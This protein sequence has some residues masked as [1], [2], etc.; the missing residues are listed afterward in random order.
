MHFQQYE[1][2]VPFL[3]SALEVLSLCRIQKST[4][5]DSENL[6]KSYMIAVRENIQMHF[7]D[8]FSKHSLKSYSLKGYP[9]KTFAENVYA[10]KIFLNYKPKIS[11]ISWKSFSM[12]FDLNIMFYPTLECKEL[13]AAGND[14]VC[15]LSPLSKVNALLTRTQDTFGRKQIE[16]SQCQNRVSKT[17]E[18][19]D[20]RLTNMHISM[21]Q[22]RKNVKQLKDNI[23]L[24]KRQIANPTIGLCNA[25]VKEVSLVRSLGLQLQPKMRLVNN[26]KKN[27]ERC[28][29]LLTEMKT[30]KRRLQH[31]HHLYVYNTCN[32]LFKI[33]E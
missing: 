13:I 9:Q 2:V 30:M 3:C 11:K 5:E 18:D 20:F 27:V 22:L 21:Q 26:K 28:L 16:A 10:L 8:L 12:L 25:V 19:Y 1:L 32:T 29:M 17:L 24:P 14:Y 33:C 15:L 7:L 4:F 31:L 23:C 6:F